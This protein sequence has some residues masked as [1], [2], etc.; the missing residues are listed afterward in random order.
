MAKTIKISIQEYNQINSLCTELGI[1]PSQYDD[2]EKNLAGKLI[3][4]LSHILIFKKALL[5]TGAIS[6]PA[7]VDY[8]KGG[9]YDIK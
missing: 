7:A 5:K 1:D 2:I 8:K 3:F 4:D 9:K 6:A